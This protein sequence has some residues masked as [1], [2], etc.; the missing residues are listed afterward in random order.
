MKL[1]Y[2]V[3]LITV[4]VC[5]FISCSKS[6]DT[7]VPVITLLGKNPDT[8]IVKTIASYNDPG[9]TAND[10]EDGN[11]TSKIVVAS[12]VNDTVVGHYLVP[13]YQLSI[14]LSKS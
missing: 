9:A 6:K 7:T 12:N 8:L 14:A 4:S 2:F 10:A 1:N 13:P 3:Y 5:V 11:I